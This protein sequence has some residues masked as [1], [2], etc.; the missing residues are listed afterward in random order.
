MTSRDLATKWRGAAPHAH[1]PHGGVRTRRSLQPRPR[2]PRARAPTCGFVAVAATRPPREPIWLAIWSRYLAG[3][4]ASTNDERQR[5][6]HAQRERP[7]AARIQSWH[8]AIHTSLRPSP[9]HTCRRPEARELSP[10]QAPHRRPHTTAPRLPRTYPCA[11]GRSGGRS[12]R[13]RSSRPRRGRRRRG[14]G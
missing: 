10:H 9:S 12:R 2:G 14:S 3:A 11:S 6:A 7:R 13:A 1:A 8:F 5:A 4:Q